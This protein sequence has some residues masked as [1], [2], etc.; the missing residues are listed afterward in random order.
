[1]TTHNSKATQPMESN[2]LEGDM[3]ENNAFEIDF[4]LG[5]HAKISPKA[6]EVLEKTWSVSKKAAQWL[7][8]TLITWLGLNMAISAD[9]KGQQ[10]LP[11]KTEQVHPHKQEPSQQ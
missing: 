2:K 11:D 9:P 5:L 6:Q 7:L 1:M 10:T 4:T 8:P 3:S